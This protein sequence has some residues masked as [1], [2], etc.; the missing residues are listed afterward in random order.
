MKIQKLF[1][2]ILIMAFFFSGS[3]VQAQSKNEKEQEQKIRELEKKLEQALKMNQAD[4]EKTLQ[5]TKRIR[6][7]DLVKILEN[8]KKIQQKAT[9]QYEKAWQAES[10]KDWQDWES[11]GENL[12]RFY[13]VQKGSNK[14]RFK[15]VEPD[16]LTDIQF[17]FEG[18]P[19]RELNGIYVSPGRAR[20]AL[21]I[22]KELDDVTFDTQFKYEVT[23]G[24]NGINFSVDGQ[25]EEGTLLI[26]LIK[27]NGK[28]LQEIEISPLADISWNQNLRWEDDENEEENLGSWI[29]VVS[30][31]NASGHYNANI[32]AN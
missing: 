16:W 14:S 23:A 25:M 30:A 27:P 8:Q 2:P 21:T 10:G 31:K 1:L 19:F 18:E 26:R 13:D 29:I 7:E 11:Q 5:E 28:V 32:R 9:E 6:E 15:V 3:F 24:S 4:M 17:D 22:R 12:R 20:T